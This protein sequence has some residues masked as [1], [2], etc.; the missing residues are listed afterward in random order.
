MRLL[1]LGGEDLAPVDDVIVALAFGEGLYM[2][3]VVA[4]VGLGHRERD[5]QFAAHDAWQITPLDRLGPVYDERSQPED[6]KM[7]RARGVHRAGICD[8][9]HH[10]RSFGNSEATAAVFFWNRDA[11]KARISDRLV[12]V[13]RELVPGVLAAPV[14]VRKTLA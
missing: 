9:A 3:D 12:E 14:L 4:G 10:E 2:R 1:R 5:V 6:R 11:Q 13:V 8:L 7:D